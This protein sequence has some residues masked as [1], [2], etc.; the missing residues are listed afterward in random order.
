MAEFKGV[1]GVGLAKQPDAGSHKESFPLLD[2]RRQGLAVSLGPRTSAVAFSR[3]ALQQAGWEPGDPTPPTHLPLCLC[4]PLARPGGSS[5][6]R[7]ASWTQG[8]GRRA[9][10]VWS[11]GE[12]GKGRRRMS[13]TPVLFS[14]LYSICQKVVHLLL[15]FLNHKLLYLLNCSAF[16]FY[17][18]KLSLLRNYYIYVSGQR[19]VFC[20]SH[21]LPP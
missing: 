19:S 18:K 2:V 1:I 9:E 21:L 13:G 11:A 16:Y 10:R 6:H 5:P 15:C 17:I 7:S 20:I 8:R 12:G 14:S 3:G 4:L